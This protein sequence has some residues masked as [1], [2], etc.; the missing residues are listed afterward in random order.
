[1]VDIIRFQLLTVDLAELR[2]I[3]PD[4]IRRDEE[5]WARAAAA[6]KTSLTN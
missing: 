6:A 2:G 3:D 1:V 5:P 4:R